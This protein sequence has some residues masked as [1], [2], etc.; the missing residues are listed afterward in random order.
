MH[1]NPNLELIVA[2][3]ISNYG[4]GVVICHKFK[5]GKIK[6]SRTLKASEKIIVKSRDMH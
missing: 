1:F 2:S 5:D 6:P 3:D 4:T